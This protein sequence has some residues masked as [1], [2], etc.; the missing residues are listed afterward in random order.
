MMFTNDCASWQNPRIITLLL[1]IFL[2]GGVAGALVMRYRLHDELHR[3]PNTPTAEQLRDL[4][5]SKFQRELDLTPAQS[6][7]LKLVLDDFFKY[8]HSLESQMDEVRAT[9]KS[10]ILKLLK[11]PQKERFEKMMHELQ[12]K[13]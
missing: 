10:R 7:E 5:L 8:Y 3:N 6:E 1:L 11:E 13:R 9:G 2:C 12:A 4:T